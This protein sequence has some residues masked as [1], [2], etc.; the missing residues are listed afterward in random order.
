M[1]IVEDAIKSLNLGYE[2]EYSV[3][4]LDNKKIIKYQEE[5]YRFLYER[6]IKNDISPLESN[7]IEKRVYPQKILEGAKSVIVILFPYFTDAH[8][9]GNISYYCMGQDYHISVSRNLEKIS[10]YLSNSYKDAKIVIQTDNGDI[11]EKFFAYNSGVGILGMNSLIISRLYGSYVNI[12]LIVSDIKLEE[13]IQDKE[14]CDECMRCFYAC[15]ANAIK[16]DFTID[17]PK[18]SSFITQKKGELNLLEISTIK[19]TK[20]IF[21][22][23][24]CQTVCH[25][26]N[27]A[28]KIPKNYDIISNI[29]LKDVDVSNKQFRTKY[30][31]RAF[32]FRGKS[33][34][35]RNI[36]IIN[37]ED[38]VE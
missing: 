23:D 21:G 35:I 2:I 16:K 24:I 4:N 1:S 33:V 22:C 30:I 36:N 32:S 20:K 18:C 27:N 15:P 28:K 10:E 13:K 3:V 8:I 12:G 25:L 29:Y 17:V 7:D 31:D 14:K 9:D 11:N 37:S 6:L 26:N 38:K 5:F 19:K 34:L